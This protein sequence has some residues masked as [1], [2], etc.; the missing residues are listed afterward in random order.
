MDSRIEEIKKWKNFEYEGKTYCLKHLSFHSVNFFDK[1]ENKNYVVYVTYSF[2]CFA[3][4]YSHIDLE[5]EESKK[6]MYHTKKESR[7]FNFERYDL[8]FKIKD[9]IN[10]LNEYP[11]F[12]KGGYD[13]FLVC[14]DENGQN[15]IVCLKIFKENKKLRIHI[16]SAYPENDLNKK[17]NFKEKISI[18][19]IL[20]KALIGKK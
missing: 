9:M 13:K 1:K 10:A 4:N 17:N 16:E 5:S 19:P 7:H 12:Y 18:F 2:H 14:K 20:K 15:Y 11:K 6:L 3:K 8:S